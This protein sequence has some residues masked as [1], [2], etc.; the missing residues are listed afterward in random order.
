MRT[1]RSL[2][3][4]GVTSA[5]TTVKREEFLTSPG[6]TMGT[7][8]YMSPE[9]AR[10]EE[11]DACTDLFSCGVLLYEMASGRSGAIQLP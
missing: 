4:A 2:V 6:I 10:R 9:Q 7:V 3:G 1:G 11:L 8:A 5:N